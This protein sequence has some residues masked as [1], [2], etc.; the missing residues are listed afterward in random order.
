MAAS[1]HAIAGTSLIGCTTWWSTMGL[2]A[3]RMAARRPVAGRSSSRPR[4]Y[5]SHTESAPRTGTTRN[6]DGGPAIAESAAI[7]SDSPAGH[8][9]AIA[10]GIDGDG[11]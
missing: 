8:S 11:M 1:H 7:A 6:T 2:A 9:G 5:A 4:Q 3:T 10:P